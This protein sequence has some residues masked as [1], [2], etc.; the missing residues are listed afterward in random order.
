MAS[1]ILERVSVR[2]AVGTRVALGPLDLSIGEGECLFVTGPNGSGKTTLARVLTGVV[3]AASGQIRMSTGLDHSNWP[4]GTVGWVQQN[5]RQQMVGATV[6][7]DIGL[8]PLWLGK[9]W[10]EAVAQG[11]HSLREFRLEPWAEYKPSHLSGGWQHM[12]ALAAVHAQDPT[13]VILDEPDA[14]LDSSGLQRLLTWVRFMKER[15]QTLLILGHHERWK[16]VADRVIRLESGRLIADE[17]MSCQVNEEWRQFLE[18]W[19]VGNDKPTVTEVMFE[20]CHG[21]SNI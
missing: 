17:T 14:M 15:R 1:I 7:E 10:D 6:A 13:L 21:R 8:A 20:L 18:G 19:W 5:P 16:E 2:Y 4:P 9:T 12:A 3:P 11:Q